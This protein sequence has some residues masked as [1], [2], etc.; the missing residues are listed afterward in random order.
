MLTLV[1]L[2][3]PRLPRRQRAAWPLISLSTTTIAEDYLIS[4][5]ACLP[6]AHIFLMLVDN[7]LQ[8]GFSLN[9]SFE[10]FFNMDLLAGPSNATGSSSSGSSPRSDGSPSGSFS[11]LPLTPPNPFVPDV[12]LNAN[13]Y[14]DFPLDDDF[15]KLDL[16]MPLAA[17]G[18]DFMSAFSSAAAQMASPGDSGS[19]SSS[20]ASTTSPTSIDPQLVTSPTAPKPAS[21]FGDGDGDDQHEEEEG[22]MDDVFDD[23][24]DSSPAPM[25]VGGRG[26]SNRRGTVQSGGVVKRAGSEKKENRPANMLSTTSADPDDW[27][28]TPEEYKKMSS[29]EKRQLRNKISA[30][31]FRVR[32]KGT[33]HFSRTVAT[34]L[35]H[36]TEYI[37]TL[38][39][40]IAERDRLIDAIRTELGSMRSENVA[41]R[42]E[43]DSLKKSLLDGRGRVDTPV[44]PPPA[45][46][47]AIS[48]ALSSG[49]ASNAAVVAVPKSPLVTPNTQKDLPTSPRMG[50]RGFWGGASSPFG[51]GGFTPV[52]TTLVPEWGS[53]LSGKSVGR[54]S[55]TLQE[56]IN[57]VL[58]AASWPN[59]EKTAQQQQQQ[60]QQLN[61]LES[62]MDAHPFT[63]KSLDP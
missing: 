45:P 32:R 63:M 23:D 39:G 5:A 46:L 4:S 35:I 26:K 37:N 6:I 8:S 61:A 12:A 18:F 19:G 34:K 55:P 48:P 54:R 62:F 14:L 29:K 30:R 3:N 57:P 49:I 51:A 52:H 15:S 20:S 41:L 24:D 42:Q 43:I 50:A 7:P 31:N 60:Q 28:P 44:L 2:R 11:G 13:A 47:P 25:K 56:N 21:E 40:D 36:P 1:G 58:N 22:D 33:S 53:V 16:P 59:N 10:D 17:P 9:S 27:R 38:E